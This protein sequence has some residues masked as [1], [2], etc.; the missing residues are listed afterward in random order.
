MVQIFPSFIFASSWSVAESIWRVAV[1][2]YEARLTDEPEL[3][4]HSFQFKTALQGVFYA[5]IEHVPFCKMYTL[6]SL[7][8]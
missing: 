7:Y 1:A 6:Y 4:V 2:E 8:S 3:V 5:Y